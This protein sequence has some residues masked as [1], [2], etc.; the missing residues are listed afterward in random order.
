LYP[1]ARITI[2]STA[3]V[4]DSKT[5]G[6]DPDPDQ[7]HQYPNG[8]NPDF[9]WDKCRVFKGH[10]QPLISPAPYFFITQVPFV[11]RIET[12]W[13]K[14]KNFKPHV[15]IPYLTLKKIYLTFK[16]I[17]YITSLSF[18][19]LKYEIPPPTKAF[20]NGRKLSDA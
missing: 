2:T 5:V 8:P 12:H 16:I 3:T 15:P 7:N 17:F 18:M 11:I 1:S 19:L 14:N 10:R 4:S 20:E 13:T 9:F 6:A